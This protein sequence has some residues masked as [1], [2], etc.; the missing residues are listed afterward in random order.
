M[1]LGVQTKDPDAIANFSIDYS[2]W[3][4]DLGDALTIAAST[5]IVSSG[6]TQVTSTF[7][8]TLTTIR[9][10]G[11][12]DGVDYEAVNHV[13]LSDGQEDEKSLTIRVRQAEA[14]TG[15]DTDDRSNALA[16]LFTLAQVAVGPELDT[17]EIE[18]ILDGNRRASTWQALTAYVP[19][20]VVMPPTRNG[21]RYRCRTG[22]TSGS[23]DPFENLTGLERQ[24]ILSDSD[25]VAWIEDGPEYANV[26]DVRQAAYECW[27]L[28]RSK[29]A[30]FVSTEGVEF[31]QVFDHCSM[32]MESFGSL[33]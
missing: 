10:S 3:L 5:W 31:Q 11:G 32:M 8:D 13:S 27:R 19:G 21:R 24:I 22:G 30:Q 1:S 18:S 33:G 9:L 15:P 14:S 12:A 2:D 4:A 28:R 23:S 26:Y 16:E 17:N 6:I 29:A 20:D 7:T 25:D